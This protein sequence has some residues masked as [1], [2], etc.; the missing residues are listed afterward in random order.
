[1]TSTVSSGIRSR[2]DSA[3]SEIWPGAT[4]ESLD[5]L[6]GHSGLTLRGSL[7][8]GNAPCAVVLKC[9]PHGRQPVGRHDVGRQ[10]RLLEDIASTGRVRVP[11]VLARVDE[12]P[13]LVVLEWVEG[14]AEEPVLDLAP[15][16]LSP[17][18]VRSRALGASEVLAALHDLDPSEIASTAGQPIRT[19]EDELSRWEPTMATVDP[20]LSSGA[21]DL[22][23]ALAKEVPSPIRPS[24]VHGDYRLGNI[25]CQD[26]IVKAV[27]DWEIWSVGDPRVDLAWMLVFSAPECLPGIGTAI[28][29]MP[30]PHQALAAYEAVGRSD[31]TAEMVW[32]DALARY[33]M[34]AIMGNNLQRHRTGRRTDPYQERLVTVI[35]ALIADGLRLIG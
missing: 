31:Q 33:K 15:G 18:V 32:F 30:R 17:E 5:S 24:I 28:D 27:I 2:V 6:T 8:G 14:R 10:A 19:P 11:S 9:C 26:E 29:G 1:M 20:D 12:T 4:V 23:A 25:L 16:T 3:I 7:S 13:P 21:D 35:P 22:A 34:A